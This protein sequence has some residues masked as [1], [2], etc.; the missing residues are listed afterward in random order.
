MS[1]TATEAALRAART[2]TDQ[3]DLADSDDLLERA[4][5]DAA[6]YELVKNDRLAG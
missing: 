2:I 1:E 6:A 4:A 5:W 3:L